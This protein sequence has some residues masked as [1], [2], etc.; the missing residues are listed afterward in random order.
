MRAPIASFLV[1]LALA[2]NAQEPRVPVDLS[3][4]RRSSG[5]DLRKEGETLELA[6]PAGSGRLA[7]VVVD[8]RP[9]RPLI[10]S[11]GIGRDTD[12]RI[13]PVAAGVDPVTFITVGTREARSGRPP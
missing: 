5:V 6:W 10:E 2:A 1:I 4:Y 13:R 11:L 3:G 8:L 7:H 9:G 12:R